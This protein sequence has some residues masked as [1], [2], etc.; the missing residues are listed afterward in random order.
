MASAKHYKELRCHQ[1]AVEIRR[2]VLKV[3][4]KEIVQR[5]FK[6]VNQIRDSARGAPRNIAEGFSRFAPTAI[7]PF[8]S[9][10]KASTD[11]TANHVVDG[12]ESGYFT[13]AEAEKVLVMIDQLISALLK[14]INYLE[15]PAAR[16]F[17]EQYR[18][19]LRERSR[20]KNRNRNKNEDE[21]VNENAPRT[22][23]SEPRTK[24]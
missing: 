12:L 24:N 16:R 1:L 14:W 21:N 15:S 19:G 17:Y 9:Y 2:E 4:K 23:N 18:T 3:T 13:D 8:V 7:L 6:F 5:D 22:K 10:A 20:N 11:E